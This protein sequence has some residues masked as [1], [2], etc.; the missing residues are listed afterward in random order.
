MHLSR[1]C[2]SSYDCLISC[3]LHAAS[4]ILLVIQQPHPCPLV[5]FVSRFQNLVISVSF[6]LS[7]S[8]VLTTF[9]SGIQE[10]VTDNR[11]RKVQTSGSA[12]G[13]LPAGTRLHQ[14]HERA[15]GVA[16]EAPKVV[17]VVIMMKCGEKRQKRQT[18]N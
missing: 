11:A 7:I 6:T 4:L 15:Y 18:K 13:V 14:A 5:S 10:S 16:H 3:P 12:L 2:R 17:V 8:V 9:K 1:P